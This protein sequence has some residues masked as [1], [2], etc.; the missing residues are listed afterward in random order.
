MAITFKA[1]WNA[2]D[3]VA[4]LRTAEK[5]LGDLSPLM[6]TA[7]VL[8]KGIVDENFE[9]EGTHTGE[10]WQ[11][12]SDEWKKQRIKM[13]K[14]SG[15]ILNLSGSLRRSILS[16]SDS[17]TATVYTNKVYAAIHNF[18]GT[19]KLKRNQNMS[20]REFMRINDTQAEFMLADLKISL[21]EMLMQAKANKKVFG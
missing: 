9:T 12:W 15:K 8:M 14:G 7:R 3:I 19:K 5:Q 21:E 6:K 10:K 2:K 11:S 1:K 20:K 17:N 18:G 4:L 16:K 13:G